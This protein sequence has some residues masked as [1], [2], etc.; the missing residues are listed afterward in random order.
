MNNK[1]Q[2]QLEKTAYRNIAALVLVCC[3]IFSAAVFGLSR[4]NDRWGQERHLDFLRS[5]FSN[6]YENTNW[7]LLD[8]KNQQ[9]FLDCV[10]G[11]AKVSDVQYAVSKHNVSA[12]VSLDVILSDADGRSVYS[13]FSGTKDT[14]H[15]ETFNRIVGENAVAQQKKVYNAV[16][17]FLGPPSEYVF[18]VPLYRENGALGGFIT[19]YLDGN[20]WSRLF[21]GY[22]YDSII[23]SGSGDVIFFTNSAFL[24]GASL[25]KFTEERERHVISI[26]KTAYLTGARTMAKENAV[27]YSFI[28]QPDNGR[29]LASGIAAILILGLVWYVM[30]RR[31]SHAMAEK[32]AHSV[33]ELVDEIR[34]IRHGDNQH[35][36]QIHT[37]DE[38]E[39][40]ASQ[41]NRMVKSINELNGHNT[42]LIRINSAM[43]IRNLQAQINPHFIYNT[44]DNIRYLIASEPLRASAMIEKFTRIL[45]YSINNTKQNVQLEEDLRYIQDYLYIQ[46]TRFGDRFLC[47]MEIE[48]DCKRYMVPK[49]LLQPFLENSIKYGFK[50]KMEIEVWIRG[51]TERDYLYLSVEDNG[52]GVPRAMLETLRAM[53]NSAERHTEHNGLQNV[54]RRLTLEYGEESCIFIDSAEGEYFKVT[55]KLKCRDV[56]EM[57][58]LDNR[59]EE[60]TCTR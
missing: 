27:L 11:K 43:E 26:D 47:S 48:E 3:L 59:E 13:S 46:G 44:L 45:R 36:I 57:W 17:Y 34:V 58:A 7:F 56:A 4:L 53:V 21:S 38:F 5:V 8:Q 19:A 50:K 30:F 42:E 33:G 29:Y 55:A 49:L 25:N 52:F 37:G 54:A 39:E 14:M 23:T 20:D 22:Q 28:Y 1:F 41:I 9:L 12:P 15:R 51:W 24:Q 32:T 2:K 40:I 35:E 18:A 60:R 31:M 16:Y 10:D 6:I